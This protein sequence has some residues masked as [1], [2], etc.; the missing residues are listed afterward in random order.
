MMVRLEWLAE[1]KQ[2]RFLS[3]R[4][5]RR[6]RGMGSLSCRFL[7]TDSLL[8]ID[9]RTVSHCIHG[10]EKGVLS[11][12]HTTQVYETVRVRLLASAK[13]DPTSIGAF[14]FVHRSNLVPVHR[15][16]MAAAR[17]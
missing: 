3:V 10:R 11:E 5:P 8:S 16:P 1:N 4:S 17:Y 7:H 15:A 2:C 12:V 14:E 6:L 9:G 13:V